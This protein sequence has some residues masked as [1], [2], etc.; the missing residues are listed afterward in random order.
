MD[1]GKK[2][3]IILFCNEV[4]DRDKEVID[5]Y[6]KN[7]AMDKVIVVSRD[8]TTKLINSIRDD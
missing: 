3:R 6:Q 2:P 5:M 8:N 4:R 7:G 1:F